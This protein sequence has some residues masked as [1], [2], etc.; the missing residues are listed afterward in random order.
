MILKSVNVLVGRIKYM[1]Y[2]ADI[3][4]IVI[5][6]AAV[7]FVLRSQIHR[8]RGGQC[9]GGCPGCTGNCR[10]CMNIPADKAKK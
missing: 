2:L 5:L 9:S 6:A 4:I 3:V 10:G 1:P 8:L 7:F